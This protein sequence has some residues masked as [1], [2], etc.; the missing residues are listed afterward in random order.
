MADKA[1][2]D[3]PVM[4]YMWSDGSTFGD[5]E[6]II[7]SADALEI[8]DPRDRARTNLMDGLE[9]LRAF[10]NIAFHDDDLPIKSLEKLEQA[11]KVLYVEQD[12]KVVER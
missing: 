5:G 1:S 2:N 11:L 3:F 6:V 10:V 9:P 4:I 7:R 12:I 8:E